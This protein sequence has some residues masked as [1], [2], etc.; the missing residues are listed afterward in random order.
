MISKIRKFKKSS[1]ERPSLSLKTIFYFF[2]TG[3]ALTVIYFLI[4]S[5]FR[6]SQKRSALELKIKDLGQQ[7][8]DIKNRNKGLKA[9]LFQDKKEEHLEEI[10]REKLN[11]Q[12]QGEK[13]VV[14]QKIE[15]KEDKKEGDMKGKNFWKK[16][17]EKLKF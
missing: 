8:Q 3:L 2:F 15:S 14:I 9:G 17:W 6:M 11:L 16:I 5:N 4:I 10:A 13:V 7:I 12:K 1:R